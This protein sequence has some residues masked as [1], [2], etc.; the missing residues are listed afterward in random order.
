VSRD[1][2]ERFERL[3]G[4]HFERVA[5]YLLARADREAAA[6]ALAATFEVAWRRLEE[7][8]AQE[9]PWLLGVARR[10][11]ANAPRSRARQTALAERMAAAIPRIAAHDEDPALS[12]R[13]AAAISQLTSSQ[14][15]ALLLIAWDGLSER[16]AALVLGCSRGAFAARLARARARVRAAMGAAQPRGGEAALTAERTTTR[17]PLEEAT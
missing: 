2:I 6:D 1:R 14:Q 8:P 16:E 11:L 7:V 15:E 12:A 13:L 4:E 10:V 17:N 5:A 9:L 3:Y